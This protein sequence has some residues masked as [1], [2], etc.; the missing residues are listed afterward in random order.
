MALNARQERI[1]GVALDFFDNQ[2]RVLGW[3]AGSDEPCVVSVLCPDVRAAA[4][5]LLEPVN[6]G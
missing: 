3:D 2:I 4:T 5:A 6:A 1:A